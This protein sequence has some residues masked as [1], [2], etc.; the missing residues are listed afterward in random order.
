MSM[1]RAKKLRDAFKELDRDNFSYE[2]LGALYDWLIDLEEDIGVDQEL[3]VIGLCCDFA[4]YGDLAEFQAD[5]NAEEYACIE[6]IEEC[7]TVIRFGDGSFIV[8]Q[9]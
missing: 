2:G 4:E 9:F 7:T 6:D 3:D 8:Q 5:Y 1:K